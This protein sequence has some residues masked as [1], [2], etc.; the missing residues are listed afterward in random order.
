MP[1]IKKAHSGAQ[2]GTFTSYT[3]GF[4]LSIVFTMVVYWMVIAHVHSG[5]LKYSHNLLTAT[6]TILAVVQL[7]T[8]L[9]FFLHLNKESKPRWNL[10]VLLFANGSCVAPPRVLGFD[11]FYLFGGNYV[12]T[13]LV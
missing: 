9:V 12:A 1:R 8:Q 5:H 4:S 2:Q 13:V 11:F 10:L 3:I 6:I 7:L